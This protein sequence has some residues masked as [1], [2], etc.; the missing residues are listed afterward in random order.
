MII[1]FSIFSNAQSNYL[2]LWEKVQKF[3]EESLPKSAL[4]EVE[5]IYNLAK[6]S[7][8]ST[9][10]IKCVL[11]KSK[12]ALIL[13]EDAQ[14]KII[15]D[16][17]KEIST[18]KAP[19]KNILETIIANLY[20]QYFQQNRWRFYNRTNTANK[21][22][23]DD[24]RTWDLHT[25]FTEIDTHFQNALQD[26]LFLQQ[27]DL[28]TFNVLLH[29]QE[30]SKKYRPTVYDF[31]ANKAL[32]FY[33]T[34][35]SNL[36][37]PE[38]KFEIDDPDFLDDNKA[39]IKADIN[40]KDTFSQKLQAL[41]IYRHLTFF[42]LRDQ[43]VSALVD[44]T[45]NRLD[46]VRQNA[47]FDNE[48]TIYLE[49]LKKL[50]KTYRKH[51][52]ST[53]IDYKI[54][55]YYHNLANQ[56]VVNTNETHRFKMIDALKVC[57]LA[58][59]K[60]PNSNGAKKCINLVTQI[61]SPSLNIT[62]EKYI[63][64]NKESRLFLRYKNTNK[65]F[66]KV[67]KAS[68]NTAKNINQTYVKKEQLPKIKQLPFVTNFNSELKNENDY[69]Q[70][71]TELVLPKLTQG[72]Y[73]ILGSEDENF[74]DI[75]A[76]S[77]SFI[78]VTNIAIVESKQGKSYNYQV[79]NRFTGVPLSG[80][81]VHIKNI[82]V[83]KYNK[84]I[85]VTLTADKNGFVSHTPSSNHSQIEIKVSHNKDY[86][87]FR[88][89]RMYHNSSRYSERDYTNN[90][91]Y[92]FTDRSI[93]RPAQTVYFKGIAVKKRE[94]LSTVITNK[95][96]L[97]TLKDVNY[98]VVKT[99]ELKTNDFGSFSGEFIL[100]N[101]GLTGNYHIEVNAVKSFLDKIPFRGD[102]SIFGDTY[103][104]VEEYK[105]P[106]FSAE[107]NNVTETF[108]LND[109]VTVKGVATAYAGS[110]ITDAK[111][112]YRVKRNVQYPKWWYWY[113]PYGYHSEAQE[114]THGETTTNDK[115]EFDITF[116]AQPDLS[117]DKNDLPI[118]NYEIS[119]DITDVNG[120]TRSTT[121]IVKVGYHTLTV[122]VYGNSKLDKD[123]SDS[124]LH[125]S[126]NNLN[127]EFVATKGTLKIYKAIAPK[128]VY[129]KR[130]WSA[131]DYK[132]ITETDFSRL[133]PHDMY[134]KPIENQQGELL[135][136][137][138]FNTEKSK[139]IVLKKL[140]SWSS[141]SYIAIAEINDSKSTVK[142]TVTDKFLF[143]LFACN[144]KKV[145]DN[146]LF[147]IKFDKTSYQP[148]DT[149]ELKIGSASKDITVVVNVEKDHKTITT[150][151]I[152]LNNEIKTMSIP[153]TKNDFGGFSI[154]YHFVNYNAYVDGYESISV[155]YPKADLEIETMTFRD[156]L[157]PGQEET[158]QFKIKG[159]KGDKVVAEILTSMYD[160]SL[161]QFRQHYWNFNPIYRSTYYN[162]TSQNASNSFG[163]NNFRVY[164]KQQ[165]YL[166][167]NNQAY[168]DLNWFGLYFGNTNRRRGY[169]KVF[170]S[171]SRVMGALKSKKEVQPVVVENSVEYDEDGADSGIE[172]TFI[173]GNKNDVDDTEKN[174]EDK[175]S[176]SDFSSVKPRT[177]FNE[178]AFFFPHLTTDSEGN[179]SFSFTTPES[180]T[181]W[182]L[183]LL[184]HTKTLNSAVKTLETVTQKELMVLPNPPRFLRQG[185]QIVISTKIANLSDKSLNGHAELQL[186]DAITNASIDSDLKNTNKTQS[187]VVDAKG[188]TQV[189]WTLDIPDNVQAV[190]YKIVAK[191]GN[192]S[193]GE[194]NVLPVLS[195]RMLVTETL[196]M[197]IRS[198]Q[199]KTFTLDKL[200]STNS[201]TRK[202]HKLTLEVTSNPAW[203]AVQALPYLMEYPYECSEQTFS[204]YYANTLASHIANSSPRIQQVFNQWKNTDALL[205]NLEKNQELKSLII[206]E[207]PWLRD[208]QSET[209]QKKRIALLFDLHKMK[210]EQARALKKL[211][212]MQ[213]SSGGFPW[214]KGS[215]YANRY[216]TQHIV[217]GLGHLKQLKVISEDKQNSNETAIITNAI[218]YLDNQILKDYNDLLK[219]AKIRYAND[220]DKAQKI[221]EY[222][223][224]NHT[225]H[226]QVHYLYTRSFF[227]N[228]KLSKE[229][230][231]AVDYYTNQS[232]N[233]WKDYNLY[234]KGLIALIA[235]RNDNSTTANKV[236][237]S[238]KENS[239]T[240]EELGMYWKSNSNSLF[241]YQ[242]P[243]ETQ[244]LMIEAFAEID[245]DTKTIDN[246]KIWLLKNKQTNRWKTTKATS[247]A[248]YA[249][250]LQGTEWIETT[251]F[252]DIT[253]GNKTIKPL[254]LEAT[255]VEAGTGYYKTSW[256][257]SEITPD[258]AKVTIKKANKGIAWGAL[259]WQ[260]FED[261]DKITSAETPLQLSKKL[262]LKTNEDRGEQLT[263]ITKESRLKLGDL[264][265]V[266]IE[267]KVDR[268]ME[269]VHMKDMRA[270]GFEPVDVISRYK[271]QDGLGYYQSTKDA[272]TNFFFDRLSKGVYV[273]EYD[274]RV[275]NKGD[276][277]NGITSIQSMYAPEFSSHS[278]GVRVKID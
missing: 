152:H 198:N 78:R 250:L 183:Q 175:Q 214:F 264:V 112:V 173:N 22:D 102:N 23:N 111:V 154:N 11:Y 176:T 140:K 246:L 121:T 200:A 157:Q 234:S 50:Q 217:S 90:N 245:N 260:Y 228:Y 271:W 274:L 206:Q 142:Q 41:K 72:Y 167:I 204:K 213:M 64:P 145:P 277:S 93:Y 79:V 42:H 133:F 211:K 171:K 229:I 8:N 169:G 239:I 177:N 81:S 243:I 244:A 67:F 265:R 203:Y 80:A 32:D 254:E 132:M 272:S 242:A 75:D 25:I 126:T 207:T 136:S 24:F 120:E 88:Y 96:V 146:Q 9:Q 256:N 38:Y 226:F 252:V 69:Q 28:T 118:F 165:D 76:Y 139:D 4:K 135:F 127:G 192:F 259:Y 221:E 27:V 44:V 15:K 45:L 230:Q 52:I 218:S 188:N 40:S 267:L 185:D 87:F 170:S 210:N 62:N 68:S 197:W 209:E 71:T 19:E 29:L 164:L 231:T 158:W 238:L 251:E 63:V 108:K 262:F 269:F 98:Q 70:H 66:F 14:L 212:K 151:L 17:K 122:S 163:A 187:F 150:K 101:S 148:D 74:N 16:I 39:F 266:R 237:K 77:Y 82:N 278:E 162:I 215:R 107:F 193:D 233:Y 104:S 149:V 182:K 33:K 47:R 216:I 191:A 261:L 273:F 155:P 232:Y 7:K 34:G 153:V 55:S 58:Q 143:E 30:G 99:L 26:A 89:F 73:L 128:N 48:E 189:S 61:K 201:K 179:V 97:V 12:Y 94:N 130:P 181:R 129:R 124:V 161:D 240:S 184:A 131:P 36:A 138:K 202:N 114:I 46:F 235:H 53:E 270:A 110:Q 57:Q 103:F 205:S 37:Q 190:Q 168:D 105:R 268:V 253:I 159:P 195:N 49:T 178:T 119:A 222:L 43:D 109:S 263:E 208:A 35:E 166:A 276:F 255:K 91:I 125:I 21:V 92:L 3:E 248:V 134:E 258:M 220:K 60:F 20:W 56:Y 106:K 199:T 115:G 174:G 172:Q 18:A 65:L 247:E 54:A 227:K 160:A 83:T 59:S 10:I 223:K 100:P 123:K 6:N 196:P 2:D 225:S 249:L 180:L 156:K 95:N 257:G 219:N 86:G 141:G 5:T 144:D 224:K 116:F 13:E 85:N 113:R 31:I 275:N 84:A 137:T 236:L 186:V 1:L 241:W 147:T 117:V 51:E 194:Q